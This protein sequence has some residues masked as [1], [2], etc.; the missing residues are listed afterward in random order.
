[1]YDAEI[2]ENMTLCVCVQLSHR[3]IDFCL[4]KGFGE[5]PED[6]AMCYWAHQVGPECSGK[7]LLGKLAHGI[8]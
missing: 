4:F 1:M 3:Q 8:E 7:L 2:Y 5:G 6:L